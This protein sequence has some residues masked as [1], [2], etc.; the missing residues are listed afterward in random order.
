MAGLL[1]CMSG[2][3]IPD[4][5]EKL[6]CPTRRFEVAAAACELGGASNRPGPTW[7]CYGTLRSRRGDVPA[8]AARHEQQ[9]EDV[10]AAEVAGVR[11]RKQSQVKGAGCHAER[12]A[13]DV[14]R[15]G[16]ELKVMAIV[17]VQNVTIARVNA[18]RRSTSRDE[19]RGSSNWLDS[20]RTLRGRLQRRASSNG[21]HSATCG[22]RETVA[23]V[24]DHKLADAPLQLHLF[25]ARSAGSAR[26][27]STSKQLRTPRRS[28]KSRG[29]PS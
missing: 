8:A 21:P 5:G 24:L 9:N 26:R 28:A 2:D 4:R 27:S 3:T 23:L 14:L 10:G 13:G 6:F 12:I 15:E 11:R 25:G 20:P 29:R 17:A 16:S 1:A 22:T 7:E 19:N 18:G